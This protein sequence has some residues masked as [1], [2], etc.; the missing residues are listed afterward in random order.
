MLH[1]SE[2][3]FPGSDYLVAAT[4]GKSPLSA[5]MFRKIIYMTYET[6]GFAKVS[7]SP[8][9]KNSISLELLECKFKGCISKTFR[10]LKATQLI[11]DQKIYCSCQ[12][13]ISK[14]LWAMTYTLLQEI[15]MVITIY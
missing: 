4:R 12:I 15:Y 13:T 3:Q 2:K 11:Q 6:L 14:K 8:K 9:D 5:F 10:H 7:W 1:W